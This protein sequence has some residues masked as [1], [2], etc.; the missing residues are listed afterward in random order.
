M[1]TAQSDLSLTLTLGRDLTVHRVGYGAMHLTGPG[2]WGPPADPDMAVRVLRRAVER[3][4]DFIDTADSYGPD[5]NE[6]L[7]RRA[8][9]PYPEHLVIATKGGLLRTGPDD[10]A[11]GDRPPYIVPLC[12][13]EYLR[14]QVE[15]SLRNLG[16]ERIDL[17][18]LH[19]IDPMVPLADQIGELV[20]LQQEG[21]IHHIGISGQPQVSVAQLAEARELADIVSVENLYNIADRTSEDVLR[22]AEQHDIAFIPWFPMG[23]GDLTGSDSALGELA[24]RY[25]ATPAQ[26]ALAWLFRHSPAILLIPGTSSLAHLEENLLAADIKLDQDDMD[27]LSEAAARIPTSRPSAT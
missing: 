1:S 4:V 15:M 14:Q 13:P 23:H 22:Y 19:R 11:G 12:R 26:L 3:G 6:Q 18:Q 5:T 17:Y 8:L 10:W 21:K 7:I 20:R 24:N 16:I 25:E 27:A 9:H 2:F